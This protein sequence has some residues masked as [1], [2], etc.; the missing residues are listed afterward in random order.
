MIN[1]CI[2]IMIS[3]YQG[4]IMSI[5][6][7]ASAMTASSLTSLTWDRVPLGPGRSSLW[8]TSPERRVGRLSVAAG[9]W[10][11]VN[12]S[13]YNGRRVGSARICGYMMIY[14]WMIW[15]RVPMDNVQHSSILRGIHSLVLVS[16]LVIVAYSY[17]GSFVHEFSLKMCIYE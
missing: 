10:C 6:A 13:T 4:Q 1:H 5:F 3:Y 16:S 8:A 14:A 11:P 12:M 17:K 7:F 9:G 15:I 2:T